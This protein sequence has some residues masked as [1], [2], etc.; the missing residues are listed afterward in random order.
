MGAVRTLASLGR[1]AREK[2]G[3][4][5][6]QPLATIKVAVPPGVQG[7]MF[8]ELIP[9]LATETNVK[10]VEVVASD[11]DLVRLRAKPNFR[12]LGKKFGA[13]VKAVAA[14]AAGLDAE[15]LRRLER[16]EA[17]TGTAGGRTIELLPEDI[18]VER[19]VVTDWPVASDGPFVV[20]LDPA[21]SPELASEGLA[22]ELVNRIQRLRKDAGFDVS[23]RVALSID[24]DAALLEAAERHRDAISF[25]TLTREFR[26]GQR[27]PTFDRVEEIVI[28]EYAAALAVR[29]IGDG[30]TLSGPAP[31]D[32]P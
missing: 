1:A 6:R 8:D 20:A 21:V 16:G 3:L 5:V 31:S 7:P 30:R 2:A 13:E 14:Y 32:Q 25:E 23:S 26:V 4:R 22:R 10:H 19:D 18:V 24:G 12:T 27:L 15:A 9:L 29:R 17:W 28:D 11:A